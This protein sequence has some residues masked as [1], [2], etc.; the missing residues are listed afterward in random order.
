MNDNSV[1]KRKLSGNRVLAKCEVILKNVDP[2]SQYNPVKKG[3]VVLNVRGGCLYFTERFTEKNIKKI[4]PDGKTTEFT[5]LTLFAENKPDIIIENIKA[6]FVRIVNDQDR[7]G[8]V[9]TF[10][11]ITEKQLDILESLGPLFLAIGPDEEASVPFND[12]ITLRKDSDF[13]LQK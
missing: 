6:L 11:E 5:K 7:E 4:F 1:D 3:Y 13:N 9:F 2:F 10:T 12:T 8:I